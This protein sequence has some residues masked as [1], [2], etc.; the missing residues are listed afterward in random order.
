MASGSP[1]TSSATSSFSR[2]PATSS[3]RW[4]TTSTSASSTPPNGRAASTWPRP[5]GSARRSSTTRR[6]RSSRPGAPHDPG[7]PA[8]RLADAVRKEIERRKRLAGVLTYDDLLT[9]LQE[10][11]DDPVRGPR[12]AGP[13]AGPLPGGAGR[14]VPGHR[15][16]PVGHPP[17]RLR[18]HRRHPRA[19][20]RPQAG[21][22]RLPGRRR[23]RLPGGRRGG[24]HPGHAGGQLAQRPGPDR[25]LRRPAARRPPRPRRHRLPRVRAA[26]ANQEP[27]LLGAPVAAPL[28]LRV[29]HRDDGLV[30]I[31]PRRAGPGGPPRAVHRRRPRRRPRPPAVVGGPGERRHAT[32]PPPATRSGPGTWPCSSAATGRPTWCATRWTPSG[33]RPSSTAPAASSPPRRPG[34]GSGSWRRWSGRRRCRGPGRRPHRLPRLDG[35]AGGAA[36][37]DAW[38]AVHARLH[39]WAGVL[40]RRGVAALLEIVSARSGSPPGADPGRRRARPHRPPPRRPAPPRRRHRRGAGRRR[41]PPG[42][43]SASPRR[44]KTP[45]ARNAAGGWN[46]TPRRCRCSPSTAA[47]ASSSRWSTCPTCGSRATSRSAAGGVPR[48]PQRRRPHDRRQPDRRRA[49]RLGRPP[50]RLVGSSG[51]KTCASPTSP[52]PGPSTRRCCGGRREGQ[53]E[54]G[55]VPAA[56]L[57]GRRRQRAGLRQP[58]AR[59]RQGGRVGRD[60]RRRRPRL[61]VGRTGH[62]PGRGAV[63]AAGPGGGRSR[64]R[65]VRPAPRPVVAAHVV[66]RHHR[67]RPRGP[68]RQRAGS[69]R[70]HRRTGGGGSRRRRSGAAA[71]RSA[72]ADPTAAAARGAVAVAGARGGADVGTFVHRVLEQRRLHHS[73][74]DG[75]ADGRGG[76]GGEP[77]AA[78]AER[79]R[80]RS[81]RPCRRPSRRRSAR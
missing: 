4:S 68:G 56:L 52:S 2:T 29:L 40:R 67:R 28:R 24:R 39:R 69:R 46:P 70:H 54:L 25:R 31:T 20:R 64:R 76:P 26:A 21:H 27:R 44:R 81:S 61:R 22:L 5:C 43:A 78:G 75:G 41:S 33:S 49:R 16:G 6:R 13:A 35:G 8:P 63:D 30:T 32:A 38:E 17:P 10:A 62:G 11:L 72:A 50:Q 71:R 51:A 36:G 80:R 12:R 60:A 65:P 47:R 42:C 55:A 14:R 79:R 34:S 73:R 48:R 3:T 66:H 9:R 59:R 58:G 15:S 1:A 77:A 7:R 53:R 57:P 37:D 18:R 19:H 23:L 45:T 74:P